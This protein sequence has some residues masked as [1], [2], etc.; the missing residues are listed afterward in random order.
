MKSKVFNN[1]TFF[2]AKMKDIVVLKA[3]G[4][5]EMGCNHCLIT[6]VFAARKYISAERLSDISSEGSTRSE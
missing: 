6:V 3:N 4:G 1:Y 2:Y 5:V